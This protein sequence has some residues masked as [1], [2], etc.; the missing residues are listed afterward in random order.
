[1][2]Q[3]AAIGFKRCH[4][5]GKAG[6]KGAE[7][8]KAEGQHG[9]P[10]ARRLRQQNATKGVGDFIRKV[11]GVAIRSVVKGLRRKGE[12]KKEFAQGKQGGR[13]L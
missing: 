10:E 12:K 3:M 1:M 13:G 5:I 11:Y 7:V 6:K 9:S 4:R 8:E 2:C